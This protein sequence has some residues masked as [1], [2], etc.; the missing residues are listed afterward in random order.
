[1]I[2]GDLVLTEQCINNTI[3]IVLWPTTTKRFLK[4]SSF[5]SDMSRLFA[6]LGILFLLSCISAG[7]KIPGGL[8]TRPHSFSGQ[9]K[10]PKRDARSGTGGQADIIYEGNFGRPG[11]IRLFLFL[12]ISNRWAIKAPHPPPYP[13]SLRMDRSF[14]RAWLPNIC[15]QS[16]QWWEGLVGNHINQT[17]SQKTW[18]FLDHCYKRWEMAVCPNLCVS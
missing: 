12:S 13:V 14:K 8:D 16:W 7:S 2:W 17:R 10:S 9:I 15:F 11:L 3:A 5:V 4:N 1:M 18:H 6:T